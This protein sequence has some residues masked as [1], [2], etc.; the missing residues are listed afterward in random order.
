MV[1][2][3][4]AERAISPIDGSQAFVV[5]DQDYAMHPE[6]SAYLAWL[7]SADRSPNT[8]RVYAG[9][10]ALFLSYCA[11]NRLYWR[12]LSLDDLARFLRALVTVPRHTH[13]SS[14]SCVKATYRS[15]GTANAIMTSVCEFLRFSATRGW[16][17]MQFAQSLSHPKFL[18]YG[19]PG[20]D[21]GEDRQFRIVNGRAIRFREV[22]TA[23]EALTS[24]QIA[25]V[26]R[27]L[28]HSRDRLLFA[29]LV[30]TGV[31]IGEAPGLRR[32]DMHLLSTSASLGCS[33]RGPH[34]HVRRRI[35]ANGALGK[36]REPRSIPVTPELV[37]L[38]AE[39][40]YE[41]S[42]VAGGDDSDFVF[43]NLY[44]APVGAPLRYHNVKKLFERVSDTVGF[45]VRPHMLRHS[46]ASR[47][48]E[49]G[50]PRN[51]VQALLGHVS[52]ASMSRYFHPSD[53]AKR[54]AVERAHASHVG[55]T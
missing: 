2:V 51:V 45:A 24:E 15:N 14:T 44:R 49:E 40:Q 33:V 10:V 27:V 34:L 23:P 28:T 8:E 16:V 26:M 3:F 38:Y 17:P 20:Y 5:V 18:R 1:S 19:P 25:T 7:R 43:V 54:A 48:L 6:A 41:R 46:A 37:E 31:R 36:S 55:S 13:S 21:W 11:N 47:W 32:E 29:V 53:E 52:P 4:T 12:A 35:N 9:R 22:E 42:D 39:Y 50:A 30:A